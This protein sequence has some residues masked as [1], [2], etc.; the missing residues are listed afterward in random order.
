MSNVKGLPTLADF[1]ARTGAIFHANRDGQVFELRLKSTQNLVATDKQTNFSV[2][3][4][5]PP[6][7]PAEQG[8]YRLEDHELGAMDLF[9]V[10]VSRDAEGLHF[11]A[12]F[13]HF[14]NA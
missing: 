11:E 8:I 4:V 7:V 10:P 14:Q 1:S 2:E 9:L 12:V 13:N 6:D 3:L 5:A